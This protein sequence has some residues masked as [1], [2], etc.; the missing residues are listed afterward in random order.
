MACRQIFVL[1]IMNGVLLQSGTL[2]MFTNFEIAH[3]IAC[4]VW[5]QELLAGNVSSYVETHRSIFA[6][7]FWGL[8]V[9]VFCYV[10]LIYHDV[11][12]MANRKQ[13]DWLPNF[14]WNKKFCPLAVLLCR[15]GRVVVVCSRDTYFGSHDAA[16]SWIL[17]I[18]ECVTYILECMNVRP[19]NSQAYMN[20][21]L[22]FWMRAL[23][24][25]SNGNRDDK[26]LHEWSIVFK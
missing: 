10:A 6:S 19:A 9:P 24:G 26:H 23:A 20:A 25:W 4:D 5:V 2:F 12:Q 16:P 14:F 11:P 15:C 18:H 13:V 8:G 3:M 22:T 7:V 21:R 17:R 1:L